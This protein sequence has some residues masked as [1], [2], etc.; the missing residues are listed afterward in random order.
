MK[1]FIKNNILGFILG[2]LIFGSIGVYAYNYKATDV[3]YTPEDHD[4]DVSNVQEAINDLKKN[5]TLTFGNAEYTTNQGTVSSNRSTSI[6]VNAGKYLII[7]SSAIVW[8]DAASY[9]S[10]S[11]NYPQNI[12]CS[13]SSCTYKRLSHYWNQP[14]ATSP[15]GDYYD[16]VSA[17]TDTFLLETSENQTTISAETTSPSSYNTGVQYITLHAIPIN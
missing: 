16:I 17:T 14:K 7:R 3:K 15:I 8:D 2:A 4:W 11:G 6:K 10:T 1:K 9:S 12:T 13:S 5:K